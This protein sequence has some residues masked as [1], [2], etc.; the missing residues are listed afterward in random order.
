MVVPTLNNR[1]HLSDCLDALSAE[2]PGE[3]VVVNGPSTDGTSGL[4]RDHDAVDSLVEVADRNLNVARNAGIAATTG[5]AVAFVDQ[6]VVV[7]EG[8]ADG[9]RDALAAGADAVTGPTR[10]EEGPTQTGAEEQMIA[11]RRVVYVNGDNLAFARPTITD[12]DGFDEYLKTGGA[13]DAAHRLAGMD[14]RVEWARDAGAVGRP[15]GD[16]ADRLTDE[17]RW[18]AKY[19]SLSYQL[20]KNYGPRPSVAGRI[21]RHAA[22]DGFRALAE[23]VTGEGVPSTWVND[24]RTV[25][26][27]AITGSR[28]GMRARRS[29]DSPTRNPHGLST[30]M[31]RAEARY[32]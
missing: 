5:D 29:S 31:D 21:V 7:D 13:R 23:V 1:D 10:T 8:W 24:G 26:G 15:G 18:A 12:L 19:R 9:V 27:S 28:D 2:A 16:I 11:G 20:T 17:S 4:A 6:R 25:L 22:G 30:R 3:L 32:D 14:R